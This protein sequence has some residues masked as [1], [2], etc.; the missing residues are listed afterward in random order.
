M[1]SVMTASGT[2][3]KPGVMLCAVTA[4]LGTCCRGVNNGSTES[5]ESGRRATGL[6]RRRVAWLS[7]ISDRHEPARTPGIITQIY[8]GANQIQRIVIARELLRELG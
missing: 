7:A 8:E 2:T 4:S 6:N 1:V 3:R 5:P